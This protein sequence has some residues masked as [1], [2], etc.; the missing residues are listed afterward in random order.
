MN[1]DADYDA[2]LRSVPPEI[3]T[4]TIWRMTAYRFALFLS[5]CSQRDLPFILKHR[6]TRAYGD[7]L[8]RAIGSISANIDEG[9]SRSS[10]RE[11]ARF[12]EYGLGS[13]REG[14]SWY[15][16]CSIALPP[17]VTIVR[18]ARVNQVIKILTVV[19]PRVRSSDPMLR[20][21]GTRLDDTR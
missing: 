9:Y 4:D 19:V 12:Y 11:R 20:Q 16:K 10:G 15:Y 14:R 6:V 21:R 5:F 3:T 18:L 13:A 17:T 1:D 8:L 7:Q 2:W